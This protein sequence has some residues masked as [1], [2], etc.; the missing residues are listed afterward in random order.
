MARRR[1]GKLAK[2]IEEEK[3]NGQSDKDEKGTRR[4]DRAEG[5]LDEEVERQ[6][7]AIRTIRDVEVEHTLTALRLLRS[8]FTEEQLQTPVSQFFEQNLPNL[9]LEKNEE[10]GQIEVKQKAKDG[11]SFMDN[12]DGLD[13][14]YSLLRR[15]SMGFPDFYGR[16]SFGGYDLPGTVSQSLLGAD[17]PHFKDLV[18]LGPSESQIYASHDALRTP[19]VSTQRLSIGMTPKSRRPPKPGE[20]LLSVHGSPLGVYKEDNDMGAI[21]EE[22]S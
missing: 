8:Y 2:P 9:S 4:E 15:L 20:M 21:K 22:D 12:A 5:F 3:N 16:S 11:E 18:S 10:N 17:N 7:A 13:M 14:H 1:A 6:I 19:G